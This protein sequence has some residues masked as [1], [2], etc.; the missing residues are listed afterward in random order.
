M[1]NIN[2]NKKKKNII[3]FGMNEGLK[4]RKFILK[5]KILHYK[6]IIPKICFPLSILC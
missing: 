3:N 6:I 4:T 5:K 1:K 2:L